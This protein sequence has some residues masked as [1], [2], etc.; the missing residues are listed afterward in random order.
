MIQTSFDLLIG[1]FF[2]PDS[3]GMEHSVSRID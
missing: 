3:D 1:V 2:G